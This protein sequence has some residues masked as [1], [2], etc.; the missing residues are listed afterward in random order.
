MDSAPPKTDF[1]LQEAVVAGDGGAELRRLSLL[2]AL[3]WLGTNLALCV[4]DLPLK[5]LLKDELRLT[6]AAVALFFAIGNFTN[7]IKPVAGVLTDSVPF[8]GTRRRHYLLL[9]I[10]GGGVL[11]LLLGSVPHTYAWLLVTYAIF[12][13]LVVVTSTTLGGR[14]VEVGN[15]HRA[16]GRL[17][18]Q[19][20]GMFRLAALVGTPLGGLL[21]QWSVPFFW[22][23]VIAATIHFAIVPAVL[24]AVREPAT[25]RVN[26]RVW[27]DARAQARLLFGTRATWCAAAMI[28]LIAASPG[29]GTPLLYYQTDTLRFS[30]LFVG[31][32][33]LVASFFG[34]GGAW[35]YFKFCR[36]LPLRT[37]LAGSILIHAL[38]TLLYL[39]Y[40]SPLSAGVITAAGGIT[41][42]LA[43]LPVYDL[44]ARATPRGS[45]ALG[46]SVM[47]SVWNLTNALSD[48]TGS[49]LFDAF[50]RDFP[51]LVLVNAG[52]TALALLAL[53]IL[54]AVL[55]RSKD[56]DG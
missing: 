28:F 34:L 7:Y 53:P 47:M 31:N 54:P 41:G 29:F 36:T 55:L 44:S 24:R 15:D 22:V 6:P 39:A 25:A 21:A 33:G 9:G 19:R 42:A 14:M 49:A 17:T 13:V 4:A 16:A 8:F 32:L 3:G 10:G 38:G 52:T 20:I 45:E 40:R 27:A 46:Y 2:I 35:L 30:K 12:Y 5:F 1:V 11:W 23:T 43:M 48:T 56:G 37:L 26:R 50:R 51:L 18:A